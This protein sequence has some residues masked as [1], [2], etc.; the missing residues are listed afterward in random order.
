MAP[1]KTNRSGTRR[2]SG[3]SIWI[4]ANQAVIIRS[5][6]GRPAGRRSAYPRAG[7]ESKYVSR[8]EP[9]TKCSIRSGS[10]LPGRSTQ[11]TGFDRAFVAL[12]H[13]PDR[14]VD[15]IPLDPTKS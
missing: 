12:T 6:A 7:R 4:D 9:R 15:A 5:S 1:R 3:A 14:L 11:Q 13:R 8:P 2:S 10:W